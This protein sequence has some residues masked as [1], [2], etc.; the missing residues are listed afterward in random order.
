MV[1]QT[2]DESKRK[3]ATHL[4]RMLPSEVETALLVGTEQQV[5]GLVSCPY[6]LHPEQ[7]DHNLFVIIESNDTVVPSDLSIQAQALN[8]AGIQFKPSWSENAFAVKIG[9]ATVYGSSK[10]QMERFLNDYI[11]FN[12]LT[13]T[14]AYQR[15]SESISD[16]S[17]TL[18]VRTPTK[19]SESVFFQEISTDNK[20]NSFILQ[21]HSELAERKLFSLSIIHNETIKDELPEIWK[22]VL[23][24]EVLAGPWPFKNHYTNE[25]EVLVQDKLNQLYLINKDGKILWK[26]QLDQPIQGE[27]QMID[28]FRSGKTQMLFATTKRL[29]LIDRNGNNVEGFPIKFED[30]NNVAPSAITYTKGGDYRILISDGTSLKNYGVDG[31]SIAGWKAPDLKSTLTQPIRFLSYAGK[32]Y[33][34]AICANNKVQLYDRTGLSRSEAIVFPPHIGEIAFNERPS[35]KDCE[36]IACDSNGNVLIKKFDGNL[37][38]EALLPVS[39][40]LLFTYNSVGNHTQVAVLENH[41]LTFDKDENVLLDHLFSE[42][43][44]NLKWIWKERS[45]LALS[46]AKQNQLFLVD[47]EKGILD[48][49]PVKGDIHAITLD[50][51][52]QGIRALVTHIGNGELVA[53][54]ISY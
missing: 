33:L 15:L 50:L 18:F 51:E 4:L 43:M 19:Q 17:L 39:N 24:K 41:L 11:G 40:N 14:K 13:D 25:G 54:R 27:I 2:K 12:R 44:S 35:L 1:H 49:M 52:G 10:S 29:H 47:A 5:F 26:K 7:A 28:A 46:D 38:T 30:E 36:L 22:C 48:K 6:Q 23:D 53:Y 37:R 21:V 9:N 8:D 32:D 3:N 16:A 34:M 42:S 20:I 45:W 31:K